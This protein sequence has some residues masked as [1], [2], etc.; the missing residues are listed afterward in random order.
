MQESQTQL[1]LPEQITS[2][3]FLAVCIHI[4]FLILYSFLS[5]L[6]EKKKKI[7]SSKLVKLHVFLFSCSAATRMIAN[8]LSNDSPPAT[9]ARRPDNRLSVTVS[10]VQLNKSTKAGRYRRNV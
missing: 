1:M 2:P 9:P 10:N 7:S 3:H 4:F 6:K 8:A 5:S